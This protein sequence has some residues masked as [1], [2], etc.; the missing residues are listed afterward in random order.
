MEWPKKTW[1]KRAPGGIDPDKQ[2]FQGEF[3]DSKISLLPKGGQYSL[4]FNYNTLW[5]LWLCGFV[6]LLQVA[7]A[8]R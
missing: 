1:S 6:C 2:G 8:L 3:E 5:V 4:G 7:A